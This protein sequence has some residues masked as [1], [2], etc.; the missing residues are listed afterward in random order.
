LGGDATFSVTSI[1][2]GMKR[3]TYKDLKAFVP[4][5]LTPAVYKELDS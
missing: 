5:S 2:G 4:I 3:K 1:C